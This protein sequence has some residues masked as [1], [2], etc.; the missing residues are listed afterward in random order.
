[1]R[2]VVLSNGSLAVLYDE[3]YYIRDIYYPLLGQRHNHSYNGHF[4]VGLWH[5]GKFTWLE[6]IRD[7]E[8]RLSGSRAWLKAHWDGLEINME[9]TV[10][11]SRPA[12]V[13]HVSI[14]GPGLV[15]VIFYHDFRLEGYEI[16]DTAFYDSSLDAV[17]HYK[18]NTWFGIASTHEIYEYTTGRRDLNV[19]LPD[20]ED[21]I[22]SK[23]PI[24][25]GSVASAV[26]IAYPEFWYFIV[27]GD[28]YR[29][30][31]RLILN[32]RD[33]VKTYFTRSLNYWNNITSEYADDELA[34]QSL[35]VLLSHMGV[36][37]SIP[38]SLDTSV[39]KFNLDTY[40]YVW[41]RDA[42]FVAMALD[43]AGYHTFTKRFYEYIFKLFGD[44]GFLFQKYNPSGTW[45][46][47]WHPWTIRSKRAL[48]IQEDETATV[49]F[50]FWKYFLKTRDY[51]LLRDVYDVITRAADFMTNFRDSKLG[52]PL[53]SFD[54][55]EERLGVHTYTAASVY[56]GLIAASN[57]AKALGEYENADK[58]EK[59]AIEV[60]E[61]IRNYLFDRERGVFYRMINVD[62][63]KMVNVDKTVDSSIMGVFLFEVFDA[64]EPILESTVNMVINKLWVRTIG[65]VAR[66]ENDYYMRVPGDYSGIPGNPWI[67]TTLWV[68]EY[69]AA[70]GDLQRARELINWV[71]KVKTPTN[72]LPEQVSPFDGSPTSV[73]P[74]LWS[75][76]EYL[77]AYLMMRRASVPS[78]V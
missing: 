74:L 77:R 38:A 45:G 24:A 19:V 43:M 9:D 26:S 51:D 5:D 65:G 23:N 8:I 41:P 11:I 58:W 36:N 2:S 12:L 30:V 49:V 60:R 76:A 55:W 52:L 20:C 21:G 46:S 40:A 63:G 56:A 16:G 64:F 31:M 39:M 15:R 1:M 7:K 71:H 73:V 17:F 59:A 61:G 6:G 75:H 37:G 18:G 62:D 57:L 22:L 13:R 25:Q 72:L 48:N 66:Y 50:A 44:E 33:H 78:V 69:Y 35:A 28:S 67:I 47:T 29:N 42:A 4:K 10:L 14:K 27:A 53:E 34:M 68:A 70:K 32:L 3:N 54:P